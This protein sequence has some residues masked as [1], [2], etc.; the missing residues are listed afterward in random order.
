MKRERIQ[1]MEMKQ[2]IEGMGQEIR[3]DMQQMEH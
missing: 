3:R 2:R 1:K